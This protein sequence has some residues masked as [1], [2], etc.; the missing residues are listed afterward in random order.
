M[1]AVL[2]ARPA[3]L[4]SRSG[5]LVAGLA[6]S[7]APAWAQGG[8]PVVPQRVG[9][10]DRTN[11]DPGTVE[12]TLQAFG[13]STDASPRRDELDQPLDAGYAP[14]GAVP[15][16]ART[17]ELVIVGLDEPGDDEQRSFFLYQD[18]SAGAPGGSYEPDLL[19]SMGADEM[20]DDRPAN[21]AGTAPQSYRA[22]A[23]GDLDGDGREEVVVLFR[24]G[25]ELRLRVVQ[26]ELQGF[27]PFEQVVAVDASIDDV[28]VATGD[29]DGDGR[30]EVVAAWAIDGVGV[31]LASLNVTAA[32]FVPFG[33][34]G[35]APV[36]GGSAFSLVLETGNVDND[37]HAEILL[38]VD[39]NADP[40]GLCRWF[41]YDDVSHGGGQMAG[42]P[43]SSSYLGTARTA[44][45]GEA[46]LGDIDGDQ[47]D[48]VLLAGLTSFPH[49]CEQPDYLV[50]AL[51][52]A[53]HGF[54]QLGTRHFH[55]DHYTGACTGGPKLVRWAHVETG[56][57][58]QDGRD[59]VLVNQW[60]FEDWVEDGD[61]VADWSLPASVVLSGGSWQYF[62]RSTSAFAVGDYT[63]DGRDDIVTVR[64][65][66][67]NVQVYTL[68]SPSDPTQ[69]TQFVR[70]GQIWMESYGADW[71]F[72]NP[73]LV[74]VHV[75]DDSTVLSYTGGR[76][77]LAFTEPIVI[78]ALAAPPY[79]LG[80]AQNYGACSTAF[81]NTTSTGNE[82]ERTVSLSAGVSVGADLDF[83][84]V[85][86]GFELEHELTVAAS[87]VSAHAYQ[88]DRTILFQSGWNEDL[89][90]FTT[91]PMDI[92]TYTV[93]TH[94]EDPSL[95]GQEIEIR[96]PRD[97]ILLQ[98][99]RAYY[100]AHVLDD[101]MKVDGSI[102]GHAIGDVSS[103]PSRTE[104]NQLLALHGGL[105]HGPV[106]VGQ[107][108]G[109]TQVT[110][111]VSDSWSSGGAL[112]IAYEMSVKVTGGGVM[113]GFSVGASSSSSLRVTSGQ[114]TTYTGTV[115]AIGAADFATHQYEF[116]LFTYVVP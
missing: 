38:V 16:L 19:Y 51:D 84:L 104:K 13:V 7:L 28:A 32:G 11:L 37:F 95:V 39:E 91:I 80:I 9:P 21:A 82:S 43:L 97:P 72:R 110:I 55:Y 47:R 52:D 4:L 99:D 114:Q 79:E 67:Q 78:A 1:T 20:E 42:G 33:E 6:L 40:A 12:E 18:G 31:T 86:G 115:G 69:P 48:E 17:D 101:G 44:V 59:E 29:F 103:Y 88:L 66:V 56:D 100:N 108:S 98:A 41:L 74:P 36:L 54:A 15:R 112:E 25:I 76:Y 116:G 45:V 3:F 61:W 30:D 23:A 94:P 26:D 71:G 68:V 35:L 10:Q 46:A 53:E 96:L 24:A 111:Q 2:R 70:Q 27:A 85:Q 90:V 8:R 113:G 50:L 75:D 102:F 58:D 87:Q 34:I 93:L 73:L 109:S 57:F 49:G 77:R 5:A 92:Y 81:G 105:Q 106:S 63:G 22:V 107:G 83:D 14:L 89:V 60:I 64:A 62:D 65:G